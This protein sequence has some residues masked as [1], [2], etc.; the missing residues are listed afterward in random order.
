MRPKHLPQSAFGK[1][2]TYSINQRPELARYLADGRIEIDNN[3]VENA[4][5]PTAIW[6]KAQRAERVLQ[7]AA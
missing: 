7:R 6:L 1:A 2:M 4:I 5:R 3:L